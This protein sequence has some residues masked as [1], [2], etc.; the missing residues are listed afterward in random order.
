ML[1]KPYSVLHQQVNDVELD[2]TILAESEKLRDVEEK[3]V[4]VEQPCKFENSSKLGYDKGKEVEDSSKKIPKQ[5]PSFTYWLN[6]KEDM[7]KFTM[8]MSILKQL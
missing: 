1:P 7:R 2:D 3:S 4:K 8:F 6:K 5:P